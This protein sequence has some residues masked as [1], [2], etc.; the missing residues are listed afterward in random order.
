MY[1]TGRLFVKSPAKTT[2]KRKLQPSSRKT[3]YQNLLNADE[4]LKILRTMG[5]RDRFFLEFVNE[6]GK[7][8][9][10]DLGSYRHQALKLL[11]EIVSGDESPDE[12]AGYIS[13]QQAADLLN[14]SRPFVTKLIDEGQ[15]PAMLVGRNR[16][17]LRSDALVFS[18]KMKQKQNV[19]LDRLSEETES[20]GLANE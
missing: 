16:R 9:K 4:L 2:A 15:L 14:V 17:V 8:F 12:K 11:K 18:E 6:K 10:L 5:R 20:L 7:Q 13:T 19:A 1:V 3:G